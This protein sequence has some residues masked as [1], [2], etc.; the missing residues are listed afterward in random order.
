[1]VYC[2]V[3]FGYVQIKF[4]PVV[5]S[6]ICELVINWSSILERNMS[7]DNIYTDGTG[8]IFKSSSGCWEETFLI[9][10]SI[11]LI[12]LSKH[13]IFLHYMKSSPKYNSIGYNGS[14]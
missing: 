11:I 13:L 5:I 1:M 4:C 6:C 2:Q 7:T 10:F 3:C 9:K 12:I 8:S 14:A